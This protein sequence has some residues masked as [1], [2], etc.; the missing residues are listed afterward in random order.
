MCCFQILNF[1]FNTGFSML[2]SKKKIKVLHVINKFYF[3]AFKKY[4]L[5]SN[6]EYSF[7][8]VINEFPEMLFD[9]DGYIKA[10]F[11]RDVGKARNSNKHNLFTLNYNKNKNASFSHFISAL[12]NNKE[13]RN[14]YEKFKTEWHDY[15][16][17]LSY[18]H[19][20]S[21]FLSIVFIDYLLKISESVICKKSK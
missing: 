18:L 6:N 17:E 5:S 4:L 2:I 11:L 12:K 16:D 1:N 19:C 14:Y 7:Y 9:E 15:I 20:Y 8:S 21:T 3:L 10:I 13:L